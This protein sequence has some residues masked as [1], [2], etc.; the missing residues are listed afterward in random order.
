MTEQVR[1]GYRNHRKAAWGLALLVVAAIAT[2]TIPLASG[3]PTKT[4]TFVAQPAAMQKSAPATAA[5]FSVAV[6]VGNQ[7]QNSQGQTPS[8]TASGS[9]SGSIANF[10]VPTPT[11]ESTTK[12]WTWSGVTAKSDAPSGSYTFTATL[13]NLDPVNSAPVNVAEFV[14]PPSCDNTSNLNNRKPAKLT[15]ADTFGS[16]VALDFQ[17]ELGATVPLGC[18]GATLGQTWNRTYIDVNGNGI[19]DPTDT[20]FPAVAL[21]FNYGNAKMLQVTYMIKNSDWVQTNAARGNNDI[22]LCAVAKHQTQALNDGSHGF[23]GKYGPSSW[24]GTNYSGVL[25]TVSNASKVKTDPAVC[26]RGSF[27]DASGVTWRTWTVCIPF[28]WDWKFG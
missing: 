5:N 1:T 25:T 12:V 13:G 14:C 6:F 15:I 8:L 18:N 17:P 10:N 16:P 21:A 24:D 2:V 26:G 28:D 19:A 20:Y 22:E 7:T 3:A 11:Y 9:P 4:L 23:I 27:I